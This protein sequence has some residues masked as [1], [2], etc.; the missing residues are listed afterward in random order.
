[1]DINHKIHIYYKV[2]FI[3]INNIIMDVLFKK[4]QLI[5]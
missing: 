2:V 1:M 5:L 3:M 4:S